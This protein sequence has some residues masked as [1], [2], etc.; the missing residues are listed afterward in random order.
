MCDE[1]NAMWL[2]GADRLRVKIQEMKSNAQ[3]NRAHVSPNNDRTYE[4]W[5]KVIETCNEILEY[6]NRNK[7]YKEDYK[8]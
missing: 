2:I 6:I 7:A 4:K 5:T 1:A 3:K 8:I